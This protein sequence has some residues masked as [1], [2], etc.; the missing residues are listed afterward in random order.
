MRYVVVFSDGEVIKAVLGTIGE[1]FVE[2]LCLVVYVI[3]QGIY[4]RVP[5]YVIW[6]KRVELILGGKEHKNFYLETLGLCVLLIADNRTK[7]LK[8]DV[9]V[10]KNRSKIR[11]EPL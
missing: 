10:K 8:Q 7:L 11:A 6:Q 1:L 9:L 3:V 2:F 5:E 4:C